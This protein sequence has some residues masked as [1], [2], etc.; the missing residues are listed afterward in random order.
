MIRIFIFNVVNS[1]C[2]EEIMKKL[3]EWIF[4]LAVNIM[5]VLA[6]GPEDM[7]YSRK[8]MLLHMCGMHKEDV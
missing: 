2:M 8:E 3:L 1:L 5:K 6:V 7:K 4:R